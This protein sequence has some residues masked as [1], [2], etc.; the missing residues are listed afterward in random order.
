VGKVQRFERRLQGIV[1]DAFA[2]VF[3]GS[4]VPQEVA[5]ALQ[6]EADDNARP[7]VG[8]RVLA[9]N[10]YT[11]T[12][13]ATDHDRLAGDE[14]RVIRMLKTCIQGHLAEQAWD[15]YGDVVVALERSE[16]LHTGQFRTSSSVDPDAPQPCTA[17]DRA[18]SQQH[19]EHPEDD[20]RGQYPPHREYG[21]D[22]S[23]DGNDAGPR[24]G[25]DP[26]YAQDQNYGSQSYGGQ[27]YGNQGGYDQSG[28]QYGYDR[29]RGYEQG[30]SHGGYGYGSSYGP[31]QHAPGQ[32]YPQAYADQQY[33]Q[34]GGAQQPG[35]GYDPAGY[36][37]DQGYGADQNYPTQG[38]LPPQGQVG[39][40]QLTASFTLDDGSNRHYQLI[41]G[42]TVVG[43]GQ[44]A[45]FRLPDTGVSRR[46]LEITWDGRTATLAD[47]GSTN[48]TTVNG[49]P[50]QTWQLVDGDVVRVGHSSLVFRIQ[51]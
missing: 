15:I 44:D 43:R 39:S 46:H 22:Q 14:Q 35:Y 32:G 47:L 50:V 23:R 10:R 40:R 12:L 13:G 7:L 41:E 9:P 11:V 26:R 37:G 17:G 38:Y 21:D 45:Q 30:P 34:Y 33:G 48:G 18:M 6:R 19:G 49:T 20:R 16:M 36:G 2:R 27:E 1:G 28:D 51:G 3:G 29:G 25:H 31:G 8:G 24:Y 5:Q 42:A 4:V